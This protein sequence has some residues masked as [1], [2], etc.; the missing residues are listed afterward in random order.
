M[1]GHALMGVPHKRCASEPLKPPIN[2]H[3]RA[4]LPL[5][6]PGSLTCWKT[7][8]PYR[9]LSAFPSMLHP[10]S[11]SVHMSTPVFPN[12]LSE[13]HA[14]TACLPGQSTQEQPLH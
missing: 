11:F 7:P 3:T 2:L 1:E 9:S 13:P 6:Q 5:P 12:P 8:A 4:L 10:N 14:F